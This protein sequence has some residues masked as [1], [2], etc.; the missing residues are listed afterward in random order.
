MEAPTLKSQGHSA[1]VRMELRLNGGCVVPI[2]QMGPD[3]LVVKQ[4][5]DHPPAEAEIYLRI[6]DSESSWRVHLVEGISMGR[7]KT[8]VAPLP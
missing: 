2:A 5:F 1:Q 3:F 6:D 4:P 7:R 8:R